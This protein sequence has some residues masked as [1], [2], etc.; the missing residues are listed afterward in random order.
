MKKIFG[1]L[2]TALILC[3]NGCSGIRDEFNK[4][5]KE[6]D[7]LRTLIEKANTNIGA[8]QTIVGALQEKDYVTGVTPIVENG[9]T[10]G[11]TIAFSKSGVISIYNGKDGY[12]PQIG[13]ALDS[14]EVYYWTIDNEWLLDNKGNK[15]R[16]VGHDGENGAPGEDGKNG[17]TPQLK[18]ENDLWKISYNNGETWETL[19]T[20]TGEPGAAGDSLFSSIDN[21][22]SNFVVLTL[23][24]GQVIK[25]PTWNAFEALQ[26]ECN[27]ANTNIIAL[28]S[29]VTALQNNDFVTGITQIQENGKVIGYTISFSKSNNITIYHGNNG[30]DGKTPKMGVKKHDD[31]IYYWTVD[32]EWLLDSENN[33]VK[34]VGED[35]ENGDNGENGKDAV[36]PQ[37]KIEDDY[38]MVSY[39]NGQNWT[40]LGKATTSI[41]LTGD[42][43]F[44][45]V[46]VGTDSIR[47]ILAD[48]EEFTVP[49]NANVTISFDLQGEATG[50]LPGREIVINYTLENATK[51]TFVTASSNGIYTVKVEA[52]DYTSGKIYVKAPSKPDYGYI[53]I[54]VSDGKTFSFV[55]VIN[56]YE[57]KMEFANGMEYSVSSKGATLTIPFSYNFEHEFKVR[58]SDKSWISVSN[59]QTRAA[60]VDGQIQVTVAANSLEAARTGKIYVIPTHST[61]EEYTEITINQSSAIFSVEQSKY[62][63]IAKGE[64]IS[65]NISSSRGL[66]AVVPDEATDWVSATV[67]NLGNDNYKL[68]TTISSNNTDSKRSVKVSLY[69]EDG[70]KLL[71]DIE[72]VQ[73]CMENDDVS[74]MILVVRANVANDFTAS[75]GLSPSSYGYSYNFYIDWGDGQSETIIG[76]GSKK[77]I[78]HKYN[79]STPTNYT[80]RISGTMPYYKTETQCVSEVVQWGKTGLQSI[81]FSGNTLLQKIAG[82]EYA[83]FKNLTD[84]SFYGCKNLSSL[85]ENL[86]K[87]CTNVTSFKE[88]FKGC[89]ALTSLPENLFK[90]CTN[91]TSFSYT[92]YNCDGLTSLPEN[93]FKHNST[94]TS[95]SCTFGNCDRLTSLPENLFKYCTN[96]TSF[97]RTFFSCSTLT[98]LPENLFK[99][100]INVTSFSHT[101]YSCSALAS[102]PTGL[103]DYNRRVSNFSNT[104]DGC[105]KA[106]GES[107]YTEIDGVKYH[108]YERHLNTDQFATPTT[109]YDCFN[110]CSKLT[111]LEDIKRY[112]WY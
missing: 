96:V 49:R 9:E 72:Y 95:F 22:D 2:A 107:P 46:V 85:P 5:H 28:Q 106:T 102:I 105:S 58:E 14:D 91:V 108:L 68:S 11:Y 89:S 56:F 47:F 112:G 103:F 53:N 35:G 55:K 43:I 50:I 1:I 98:S 104:F 54:L 109:Y 29:I 12:T 17:I 110:G 92:F 36:T 86:F 82:D 77:C 59:V 38:W 4:I 39:D 41:E 81:S 42:S 99:Y 93:L 57:E 63:V 23:S 87:Y 90:Y 18:I 111:D 25:L 37:F 71:G 94:V 80:V 20:A 10:L 69:S 16:A 21:T 19:G 75:F 30:E 70:V 8:L 44:S 31:G 73:D 26:A 34:A 100:C 74:E 51:E 61:G 48:G 33:K 97:E 40:Q 6:I 60:M 67:V 24:N 76:S 32:G 65:T 3:L 79:T 66:K 62:S 88:T 45:D 13:I 27:R 52:N 84:I 101:F 78:S 7:E 15:V 83:S 64:T